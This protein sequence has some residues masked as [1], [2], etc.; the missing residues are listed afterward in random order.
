MILHMPLGTLQIIDSTDTN[1]D[2]EACLFGIIWN[3][4]SESSTFS[5]WMDVKK[6]PILFS[7]MTSKTYAQLYGDH[8]FGVAHLK[9]Y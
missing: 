9:L 6:L 7:D 4:A 8:I 1:L 5:I 3:K 2:D